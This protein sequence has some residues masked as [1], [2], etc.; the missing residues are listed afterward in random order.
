MYT[1]VFA[2]ALPQIT[3]SQETPRELSD[4]IATAHGI[5]TTTLSNLVTYESRWDAGADN[6]YDRG[7]VQIN[8]AAHPEVSDSQAFDWSFSLNFAATAISKGE[9]SQWTV[10]SCYSF[11][12][13]KIPTLPRQ[14]DLRPNGT[15]RAGGVAI[16]DFKGVPHY[17]YIL[18]LRDDGYFEIGANLQPCVVATRFVKWNNPHLVGFWHGQGGG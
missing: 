12:K 9:E 1:S 5:P 8:R 11:V 7:P 10:C 4:E 14:K 6:G 13:T 16:Y 3:V 18:E 15:P 2:D 17:A